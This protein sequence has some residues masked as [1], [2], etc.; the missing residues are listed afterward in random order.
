MERFRKL[1]AGIICLSI[2]VFTL[3]SCNDD[4]PD[5]LQAI[6]DVMIQDIKTEE[7]VKYSVVIYATANY[8]LKSAKV[9]APGAGG[10]VYNLT[11]SADKRF[12]MFTPDE[13]DY[14]DE[15][16]VKGDYTFELTS[17]IDEKITGKDVLGDEDLEPIIIKTAAMN[18]QK[19]KTTWDKVD[20]ADAYLVRLYTAN[21]SEILY[22]S[23]LLA[24]NQVEYEFGA[25]SSGWA[26]GKSPVTDTNYL[27]ELWGVRFETGVT[28]DKANNV[29]FVTI[30]SKTIKWE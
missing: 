26:S 28:I 11:A 6:V 1:F 25:A 4:D 20:D 10:E 27:V 9:T 19:L 23:N 17:L 24:S 12:F 16:P 29:Q 2:G 3:V 21:K 22:S 18:S 8:E 14:T 7:G 5:P 30:D 13:E 15:L